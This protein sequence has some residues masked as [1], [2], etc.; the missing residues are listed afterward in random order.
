[1]LRSHGANPVFFN[2]KI[3]T[4]R[5]KHSLTN[6]PPPPPPPLVI[7]IFVKSGKDE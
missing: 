6:P 7:M 3:K 5:P 4:G 1:M 2:N